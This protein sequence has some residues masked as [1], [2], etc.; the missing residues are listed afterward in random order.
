MLT[1]RAQFQCGAIVLTDQWIISAAHCVWGKPMSAFNV[2][3]GEN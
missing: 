3:V 1:E 2:T